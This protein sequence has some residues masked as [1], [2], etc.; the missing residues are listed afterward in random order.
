MSI[1]RVIQIPRPS[2]STYTRPI[3]AHL[4]FA[5][6]ASKLAESTELILDIPGGGFV[7]M[8]PEHHEERL[9]AWAEKTGRPVLSL[10]YGKAPECECNAAVF[11]S[12]PPMLWI[13]DRDFVSGVW[14]RSEKLRNPYGRILDESWS[15][16]NFITS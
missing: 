7:S 12:T 10:D 2:S 5:P 4:F 15:L 3:T 16:I 8:T 14:E 13:P 11:T 9:C 1:R 6:H